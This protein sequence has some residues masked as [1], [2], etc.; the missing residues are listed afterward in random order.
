MQDLKHKII[1]VLFALV[2]T[3]IVLSLYIFLHEMGHVLAVLAFG[4]TVHEVVFWGFNAGVW[5]SGI[6]G[7]IA[8]AVVFAMGTIFPLVI[9]IIVFI[10]YDSNIYIKSQ[11]IRDCYHFVHL[12]FAV[13]FV[14]SL[15]AWIFLFLPADQDPISFIII[16]G[17]HPLI[18]AFTSFLLFLLFGFFVYKK[19]LPHKIF[20]IFNFIKPTPKPLENKDE[21]LV[22]DKDAKPLLPIKRKKVIETLL[23]ITTTTACF[24]LI[25]FGIFATYS[26]NDNFRGQSQPPRIP[27]SSIL[28]PLPPP[29]P[30]SI[31]HIGS[32]EDVRKV[33][34]FPR[35]SFR[36]D[37][38]QNTTYTL[39][40]NIRVGNFVSY[41]GIMLVGIS[42]Y[43]S[44]GRNFADELIFTPTISTMIFVTLDILST[45][46]TFDMN[47][48][49]FEARGDAT[50][51]ELNY[52]RKFY[53]SGTDFSLEYRIELKRK[54]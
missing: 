22:F 20:E 31:I 2:T 28:T 43:S 11:L 13:I 21:N 48:W 5:Y 4:G 33:G 39:C 46:E 7:T 15:F 6:N 1:F 12:I 42:Y 17:V 40:V 38:T 49:V 52:F 47:R 27:P 51:D 45:L 30:N 36:F 29:L 3:A 16:T 50:Y 25:I 18:V 41:V 19:R 10:F 8:L 14:G 34:N 44:I 37:L 54:E 53:E 35:K 26:F 32:I 9:F 23:K 24:F